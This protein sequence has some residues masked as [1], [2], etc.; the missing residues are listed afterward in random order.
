MLKTKFTVLYISFSLVGIVVA[1]L[2][3][4]IQYWR[5]LANE[6]LEEALSYKWNT[7]KAKNVIVFV[8]DGMS[9]DTITASRIYRAGENS[10][11]AWENFPHIGILKT[12]NTNK[13]VPDSASTATALF[14][15]VKTNFDLVGLDAN[16]ELNNCS[17]SLKTDYHVD[18]IISWAQTTG[19]DTGFVTT[20]RVTHATPAPLYAHSANRRWECESKMPKTAEKCKDIARQLVED[21]PGRNIKVIMGGGRQMLKTNA[22]GT[23]YDPIDEWAGH[24]QDGKDLIEEWKRD[25]SSRGLAFSVVQNNEELSRVNIDKIDYLLGIFANGHI[26]MDWNRKK[27]P[28][29]QPSLEDMTVTA[30]KILQK[31]KY[32][33]LLVVE[34]GLIDFAHHRGHA[35]QALLETVRFSDAINATLKMINT[36][37]TLVIVTSDH[38]HSMSFNGYSD[39]GSHILGIAQKSKIDGIPYTTLSYSTG[40]PNNMAYT[41]NNSNSVRIDPSKENTTEF[42]YSQQATIISDEAYHGGGDVA[43]Y[44]I[45][46]Y[47]HLFHSVHEQSYVALVI[48]HAMKLKSN[49]KLKSDMKLKSENNAGKHYSNIINVFIYCCLFLLVLFH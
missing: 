49:M 29:G 44:A 26:S 40:G 34:G 15:G 4:D 32:G 6:E 9:P 47:A 28:K 16:V 39:R 13:Q 35:A 1:T 43:V 48:A 14:G 37:D 20:T 2:K 33:Y 11:L 5:E 23:E 41:V 3:E 45:G 46:P 38:T 31:S 21:L 24:R 25:K 8:G 27:G 10:R 19:K 12:Y 17:K 7:N 18:S 22:T 42:T 36:Q 30:L